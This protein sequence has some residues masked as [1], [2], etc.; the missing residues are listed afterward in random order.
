MKSGSTCF[1]SSQVYKLS[2]GIQMVVEG[3]RP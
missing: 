2:E 1:L 3:L